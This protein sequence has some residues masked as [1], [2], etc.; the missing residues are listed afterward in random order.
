MALV[1][2][3]PGDRL[4]DIVFPIWDSNPL[5]AHGFLSF[6]SAEEFASRKAYWGHTQAYLLL[7]Y[8]LYRVNGLVGIASLRVY[9]FSGMAF[10][11][12]PLLRVSTVL[13]G[14]VGI[15]LREVVLSL[16][17]LVFLMTSPFY[18]VS[19]GK[20]NVDNTMFL[21]CGFLFLSSYFASTRSFNSKLY[22]FSS[23]P[24]V[25]FGPL[26]SILQSGFYVL[27]DFF[28]ESRRGLLRPA[29][30]VLLISLVSS[31]ISPTVSKIMGYT[32]SSSGWLFRAGLDGDISYFVN[33]L[34]SLFYPYYPRSILYLA[35]PFVFLGSQLL[36]LKLDRSRSTSPSISDSIDWFVLYG[37][38]VSYYVVTFALWPQSISI[39][40]YLYDFMLLLPVY[41]AIF[42][43]FLLCRF[44]VRFFAVMSIALWILV[45]SNLIVIAQSARNPKNIPDFPVT[46]ADSGCG[47]QM[48]TK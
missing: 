2:A 25:L 46:C 16:L 33:F 27:L 8:A 29:G 39:H 9:L 34:Q 28:S 6:N 32:T 11:S 30:V 43:N 41:V 42:F 1:R 31:F 37:G 17:A 7:M 22:L 47:E 48:R 38:I 19:L 5:A 45:Q 20:M 4:R 40:P 23:I 13:I 26:I 10:S 3:V 24:V 15:G 12:I 18:W 44:S 35:L 14:K 21:T 36:C